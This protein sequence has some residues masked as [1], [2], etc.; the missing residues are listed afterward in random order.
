MRVYDENNDGVVDFTEFM[1]M[2]YIMADGSPEEVLIKIFRIFDVNSDGVIS[3]HEM[4]KL[5]TDMYGML[6]KEVHQILSTQ[7]YLS[8]CL[9]QV[10]RHE[11]CKFLL[12]FPNLLSPAVQCQVSCQAGQP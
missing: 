2:Y 12:T 11:T 8:P 3:T 1:V 5:I 4:R 9:R 6:K 7:K 10:T